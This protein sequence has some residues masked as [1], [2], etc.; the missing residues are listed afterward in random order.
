M[1]RTLSLLKLQMSKSRKTQIRTR[2]TQIVEAVAAGM[3]AVDV[4]LV[5]DI[6]KLSCSAVPFMHSILFRNNNK[7]RNYNV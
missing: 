2:M 7:V 3:V 1:Y 6:E 4:T 5:A